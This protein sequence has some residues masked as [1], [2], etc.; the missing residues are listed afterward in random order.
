MAGKSQKI[1]NNMEVLVR[2]E[3]HGSKWKIFQQA[4]GLIAAG[5]NMMSIIELF[6][7]FGTCFIP[8]IAG[9]L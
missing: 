4:M 3:N 2:W 9:K 7:G 8:Q 5:G 6:G 1:P